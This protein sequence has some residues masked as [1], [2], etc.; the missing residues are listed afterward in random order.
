MPPFHGQTLIAMEAGGSR[1]SE[2]AYAAAT[3]LPRHTHSSAFF[4]LTLAGGY[5]EHHGRRS[6]DYGVRSIAFHPADEE[7]AVSVGSDEVR[8]L[9]VEVR[10]EWLERLGIAP[11][12]VR[13][14]GGPLVWLAQRLHHELRSWCLSLSPLVVEGLVLEMLAIVARAPS[15]GSD[16]LPPPWL[17]D[18]EEILCRDYETAPTLGALAARVGVHPVHLSRTWKRFR[19]CSVGDALR[20]L[21]IE[22]ACRRLASGSDPIV[23]VA[24]GLGFADQAHFSRTFR[25][26]TGCTPRAWRRRP[27][28]R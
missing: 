28:P 17:A 3:E 5:V 6:V 24:L 21:R 11:G 2:N 9:N 22:E 27:S 23:E 1:L 19:Q 16:R 10:P 18:A 14:V 7:H 20:R 8:C 13:A 12:F 25:R 4:S 26:M 15:P